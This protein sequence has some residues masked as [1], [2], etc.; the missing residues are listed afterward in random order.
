MRKLWFTIVCAGA[1]VCAGAGRAL[2]YSLF[3]TDG[4]RT[5]SMHWRRQP[6]R[7]YLSASIMTPPPN[8]KAG[9][10]LE[11]AVRRALG[12]WERAAG[13]RFITFW[14]DER[15]ASAGPEGDGVSLITVADTPRNNSFF[16]GR[17]IGYTKLFY[18]LRTG[19]IGEADILLN[20][21]QKFS[22]DGSPGTYD[23]EA[24][25]THELGHLLGLDHSAEPGS[26]MRE[27]QP[28]NGPSRRGPL[29]DRDLG[30]DDRAGSR[31]L[32]GEPD[33]TLN[34]EE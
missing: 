20:P 6:V 5:V 17:G 9:S 15:S 2:C 24:T 23:L 18:N 31:A 21:R 3:Y 30:V 26:V 34:T 1:L 29:N 25:L 11:G 10:D 27:G 8:I 19:E 32:Y 7:L 28:I 12:R 22:T 33:W 16:S 14:T 13:V 4:S